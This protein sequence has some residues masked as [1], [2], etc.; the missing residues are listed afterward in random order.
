MASQ[1]RKVFGAF[2]KRAPDS[3]GAAEIEPTLTRSGEHGR[4]SP[5]R[6]EIK[7]PLKFLAVQWIARLMFLFISR[8]LET[9][10]HVQTS[11]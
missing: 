2:E 1:A 10:S 9:Y 7:L 5:I 6:T 4:K 11:L 8:R 3:D